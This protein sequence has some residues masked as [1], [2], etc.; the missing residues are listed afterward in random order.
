MQLGRIRVTDRRR[1]AALGK[2]GAP[3]LRA[4]LGQHQRLPV[5]GQLYGRTQRRNAA[6]DDQK[7]A[8]QICHARSRLTHHPLQAATA[9]RLLLSY[10]TQPAYPFP[11]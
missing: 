1:D 9:K 3:L 6:A 4:A 2:G 11:P 5:V 8:F 10:M 7:I